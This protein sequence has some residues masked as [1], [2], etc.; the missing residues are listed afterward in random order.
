MPCRGILQ[1]D[2]HA[3]VPVV[4][5]RLPEIASH[6]AE[7]QAVHGHIDAVADG[8]GRQHA[9]PL[10]TNTSRGIASVA[11]DKGNR[12]EM[13]RIAESGPDVERA[14]RILN[15]LIP[16]YI[17]ASRLRLRVIQ[18]N[19][20]NASAMENGAIWVNKGLLD[21]VSDDELAAVLAH[22]LA[23]Y[24]G[25]NP[26]VETIRLAHLQRSSLFLFLL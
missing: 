16:P 9:A 15:R 3:E 5:L 19:V 24:T 13:G 22:E 2:L 21:D 26:S 7:P 8:R 20:W 6:R 4:R 1:R 17:P 11:D 12:L 18:T 10:E 25:V 23:H 14:R